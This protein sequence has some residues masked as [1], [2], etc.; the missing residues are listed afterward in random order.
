[1]RHFRAK[2]HHLDSLGT[3]KTAQNLREKKRVRTFSRLS[4]PGGAGL[5]GNT[6]TLIILWKQVRDYV[7]TFFSRDN[8]FEIKN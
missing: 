1:M 3:T 2:S 6:F 8:T 7:N 5:I 4:H